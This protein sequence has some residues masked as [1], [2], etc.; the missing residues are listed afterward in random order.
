EEFCLFPLRGCYPLRK[1]NLPPVALASKPAVLQ[2]QHLDRLRMA[3]GGW[4]IVRG[5]RSRVQGWQQAIDKALA[6]DGPDPRSELQRF[7]S[8]GLVRVQSLPIQ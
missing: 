6:G 1:S 2:D 3:R 7:G 8:L 4:F 5:S